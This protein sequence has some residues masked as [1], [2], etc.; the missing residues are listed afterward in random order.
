MLPLLF[1][2]ERREEAGELGRE[3]GGGGY[4]GLGRGRE[5]EVERDPYQ[6]TPTKTS[7]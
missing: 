2:A 1:T 5:G 4:W 3:E 6:A 7:W